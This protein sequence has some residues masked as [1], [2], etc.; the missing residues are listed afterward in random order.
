MDINAT[1]IRKRDRIKCGNYWQNV[2]EVETLSDGEI[3][4]RANPD[5]DGRPTAT[6]WFQPTETVF[7]ARN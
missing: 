1:Q 3:R 4:V 2:V 5:M 7:V 6:L